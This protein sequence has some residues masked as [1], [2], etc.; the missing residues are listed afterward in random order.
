MIL[1][2][3]AYLAVVV[4]IRGGIAP[5]FSYP[6][7][8]ALAI[9]TMAMAVAAVFAGGNVS[10]GVREDRSNR[11]VLGAFGVISLL[12]TFLSA[13]TDRRGVWT[14]DGDLVRWIGVVL[15]GVGGTLR[16]W[17]VFVLGCDPRAP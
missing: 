3:A 15:Y 16:I 4:I 2:T 7:L 12:I 8:T 17:P 14:F 10:P 11:W 6:P 13:W 9:A 5:F 1:G